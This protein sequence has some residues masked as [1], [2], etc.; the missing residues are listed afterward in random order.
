MAKKSKQKSESKKDDESQQ[1]NPFKHTETG[2]II[3]EDIKAEIYQIAEVVL[4]EK[5]RE[6]DKRIGDLELSN[7]KQS[8][9]ISEL[10]ESVADLRASLTKQKIGS[11][12]QLVG[13]NDKLNT[14]SG[15]ISAI[16][17]TVIENLDEVHRAISRKRK[18]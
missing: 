11:S 3:S 16:E 6:F 13:I 15:N 4:D 1:P 14:I 8:Q 9:L 5:V 2:K 10:K 12:E 18:K 7:A 17:S